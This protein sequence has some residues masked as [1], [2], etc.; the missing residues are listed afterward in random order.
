MSVFGTEAWDFVDWRQSETVSVVTHV[1]ASQ[2][3]VHAA[4]HDSGNKIDRVDKGVT[5]GN[6]E[7]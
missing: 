1:H 3:E 4:F 5:P 6:K 7:I 2:L